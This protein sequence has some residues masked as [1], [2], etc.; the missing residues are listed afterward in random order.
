MAT[1]VDKIYVGGQWVPLARGGGGGGGASAFIDLTD[2]PATYAGSGGKVVSVKADVSGLEFTTAA[3]SSFDTNF[4]ATL[5]ADQV[6]TTGADRK[7]L[8]DTVSFDGNTEWDAINTY[9]KCKTTG[10]YNF[11]VSSSALS[12]YTAIY[13]TLLY[14]NGAAAE[15]STISGN[16][17][18]ASPAQVNV[19]NKYIAADSYVEVYCRISVNTSVENAVG[20]TWFRVTR[21]K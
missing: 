20:V 10:Y 9:W 13:R 12:A 18:Y 1:G 14:V 4:Y 7:I 17:A 6:V 5:S 8:F 21:Y 2:V 3:A 16:S 19:I 11:N 15:Y